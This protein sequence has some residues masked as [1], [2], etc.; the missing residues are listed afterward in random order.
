ML[1]AKE[2]NAPMEQIDK[3]IELNNQELLKTKKAYEVPV[4]D[5]KTGEVKFTRQYVAETWKM[6]RKKNERTKEYVVMLEKT[7]T[8][9]KGFSYTFRI[10]LTDGD[11][12]YLNY[13]RKDALMPLYTA[14]VMNIP[15]KTRFVYGVSSVYDSAYISVQILLADKLHKSLMMNDQQLE[16]VFDAMSDEKTTFNIVMQKKLQLEDDPDEDLETL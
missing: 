11:M 14:G 1:Y 5:S 10:R 6:T 16:V 15:V 13:F 8:N 4:K 2:L 3:V 7:I 9:D 12:Q